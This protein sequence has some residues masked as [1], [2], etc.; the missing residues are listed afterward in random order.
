MLPTEQAAARWSGGQGRFAQVTAFLPEYSGLTQGAVDSVIL[1]I[2]R[3]LG[4]EGFEEGS[5]SAWAHSYSAMGVLELSSESRG[6]VETYVTGVGGN[7]FLFNP[8]LL[9]SGAYFPPDSINRDLVLL[10]ETLAWQ[11]FGAT[12]VAGMEVFIGGTPY[13]IAGV[14]RPYDDFASRAA[15]GDMPHMYLFYDTLAAE[16]GHVPITTVQAVLPN[17]ISGVAEELLTEAMEGGDLEE[18]DFALLNN[19]D[20]YTRSALIGV[21]GDFGLRSMRQMGFHLPHWENAARMAE[22]VAALLLVLTLLFFI[23]PVVQIIRLIIHLWRRRKWR[24]FPAI[25]NAWVGGRERK[26]EAN[27]RMQESEQEILDNGTG[28]DIQYDLEEIIRSV[29]ESEEES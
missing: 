2:Q 19:T 22:D 25:W 28:E 4:G 3:G 24:L 8:V 23:F 6:P 27:W 13:R 21:A 12:N 26:K 14:Y 18:G 5:Q 7:F 16:R 10:N 1:G 29:R 20:R 17:P 9:I 15:Y 11:L